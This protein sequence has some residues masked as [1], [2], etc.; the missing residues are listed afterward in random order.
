[1]MPKKRSFL[2]LI[3]KQRTENKTEK[4]SG[5]FLQYLRIVEENPDI[6]T[7]SHKR[8]YR[9]IMNEGHDVFDDSD[10]R[11]RKIFDGERL[12]IYKYFKDE[13]FE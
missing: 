5:D 8:L 2:D 12:Y 6:S 9:A 4:F 11:L 3:E 13:F 10:P 7:L 1:M